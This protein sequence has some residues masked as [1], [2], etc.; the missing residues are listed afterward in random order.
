M[1]P[2]EFKG[3]NVIFAKDQPQYLPLPGFKDKDGKLTVCY[4]LTLWERLVVMVK[5]NFWLQTLTFNAP[6][7]PQK[8]SVIYP[9]KKT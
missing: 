9:F 3:S 6:L 2:L 7:Q 1:K 4:R 5:G 8:P